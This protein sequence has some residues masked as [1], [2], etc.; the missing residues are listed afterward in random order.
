MTV[1]PDEPKDGF[2]DWGVYRKEK[3]LPQAVKL[4]PGF[5]TAP[6]NPDQVRRRRARAQQALIDG[7]SQSRG[8][9]AA[10]YI[11]GLVS[12]YPQMS[13]GAITGL[14]NGQS[15]TP[16]GA[17]S[18][19]PYKNAGVTYAPLETSPFSM[20]ADADI[21]GQVEEGTMLPGQPTP[22]RDRAPGVLGQV[23]DGFSKFFKTGQFMTTGLVGVL[24][25]PL[26]TYINLAR[27]YYGDIDY[28]LDLQKKYALDADELATLGLD[29]PLPVAGP[30]R[31]CHA[32]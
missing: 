23:I 17:R 21:Q 6:N 25:Y 29:L 20:I 9:D 7:I 10:G 27:K 30:G 31:R 13:P 32:A 4:T 18:G 5:I 1:Q 3:N 28:A 14:V 19:L 2:D 26:S 11:A 16:R 24:S 22:P 15:F 12:M 8:R